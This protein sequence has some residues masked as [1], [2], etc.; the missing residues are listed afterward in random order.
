LFQ[1]RS[2]EVAYVIGQGP[3]AITLSRAESVA[4]RG[5]ETFRA[6]ASPRLI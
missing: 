6:R 5:R 2:G 3:L 4:A 1:E